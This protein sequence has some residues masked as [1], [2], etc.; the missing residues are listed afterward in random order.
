M[1]T[2]K[3][4]DEKKHFEFEDQM[5]N[6]LQKSKRINPETL[7]TETEVI[8]STPTVSNDTPALQSVHEVIDEQEEFENKASG[9][10]EDKRKTAVK[11]TIRNLK[12]KRTRTDVLEGIRN[13]N[14]MKI[15]F[16]FK[17][18]KLLGKKGKTIY[19]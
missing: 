5:D 2:I 18:Q 17:I 10:L 14:C 9:S 7:L 6:I 12:R 15:K 3:K 4:L 8:R 1:I 16:K 13:D 11:K 19:L